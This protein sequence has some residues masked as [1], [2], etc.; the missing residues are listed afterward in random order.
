MQEVILVILKIV[1]NIFVEFFK[2]LLSIIKKKSNI[3]KKPVIKVVIYG[4]ILTVLLACGAILVRYYFISESSFLHNSVQHDTSGETFVSYA[5]KSI[6]EVIPFGAY[7]Q[8]NN[9][10][11]GAEDIQWIILDRQDNRIMLISKDCLDFQHYHDKLVPITWENCFLKGWL[12]EDFF[13]AAFTKEEQERIVEVTNENPE[14]KPSHTSS[15][16]ST[17]DRVFILSQQ[18]AQDLFSDCPSRKAEPTVYAIAHNKNENPISLKGKW[19][20]RTTSFTLDHVTYVT[21]EGGVS[22][23]GLEVTDPCVGVRPVIWITMD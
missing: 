19:W 15:G 13:N 17:N 7:E 21:S 5:D 9:R 22:E 6:G 1:G 23:K 14:H 11:N 2:F 20:L 12:N 18:E 3:P 10:E 16:R 8:D 4:F